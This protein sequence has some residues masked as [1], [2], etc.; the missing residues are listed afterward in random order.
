[1]KQSLPAALKSRWR[2]SP[3]PAWIGAA[4]QWP[5]LPLAL[6]LLALATVFIFAND[7]GSFYRLEHRHD[8]VSLNHLSI[9][10]NMSPEH[11]FLGHYSRSLT[12]E[13]RLNYTTYTRF[14]IGG[15]LLIKLFI[16]PFDDNLAAQIY[17][18]R[19][20]MLL[21]FAGAALLAYQSLR[22]LTGRRWI[23]LAATLFAFA[24][25]YWL[26]LNDMVAT[27]GSLDF[28]AVMLTFHGMA[29]FRQEGRFRQLLVK[30]CLALL[31]GWHS[32]A[33]LLPFILLGLSGELIRA[34][35]AAPQSTVLGR[36][37]AAG[38]R[39]LRSRYLTLGILT[40]LFG[41]ALLS[42][43][44]AN[45]YFA[46]RGEKSLTELPTVASMNR[47]LS[48]A[49]A[50]DRVFLNTYPRQGF[51]KDQLYSIG[52]MSTPYALLGFN[53]QERV[54]PRLPA[55]GP[56]IILGIAVTALAL[57]GLAFV[58][59]KLLWAALSLFG[60][61]WACLAVGNIAQHEYESLYYTGIPLAA[62]SF[63][64]L[65][66]SRRGGRRLTTTS[67]VLALLIFG[68]SAFQMA[69]VG[70]SATEAAK[71]GQEMA[72][73]SSIHR[74]IQ[75]SAVA[76]MGLHGNRYMI[77]YYRRRSVQDKIDRADFLVLTRR[78]DTV[79]TLT[80]QNR[81]FFLYP[82]GPGALESYLD[83]ILAQVGLPLINAD[84][85]VYHYVGRP[86]QRGD[87]LFYVK[88]PCQPEDRQARF[89]LHLIPQD[90]AKLPNDR[91]QYGFV[92]R[93][94]PFRDYAWSSQE[95]CIAARPLPPYPVI[96]IRT[97]QNNPNAGP[98]WAGEAAI[99]PEK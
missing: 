36:C 54:A 37:R 93:D 78:L 52:V 12:P 62:F 53:T 33:L 83:Q 19:I 98:I 14:P 92:N 8:H 30:S 32:Y 82:D 96:H 4:G 44:L 35:A 21:A 59:H 16:L 7:R 72:E 79:Q 48:I 11:R 90:Q 13:G 49:P 80:P 50:R 46:H 87:W 66:L 89:F 26:Y 42:F 38:Y 81:R 73:L 84:Y 71:Q 95:R 27:E 57:F 61:C 75:G 18:A 58:S 63:L 51:L 25:P 56:G 34:G 41:A 24:A 68:F 99:P 45:E 15:H 22:R 74:L 23:A 65:Y 69:Q 2:N 88:K 9:A 43:N 1:M 5:G 3:L 55:P 85:A 76:Q 17:S 10:A 28:F 64:L 86:E 40:F 20:L 67:V 39:L 60:F 31:L 6:L 77:E 91:Q 97:G 47:S 70:H 29:V 94:F